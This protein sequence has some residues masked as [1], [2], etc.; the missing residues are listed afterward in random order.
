MS[1]CPVCGSESV[2]I[3]FVPAR[4]PLRRCARCG[5]RFLE[6]GGFDVSAAY[7]D[8]YEG[9]RPDA[10]FD[11]RMRAFFEQH[12]LPRAPGGS[13]LDVGCGGGALLRIATA[14]GF[15]ALGFDLSP[16]AV[17]ACE[18]KGLRAVAGDFLTHDFG[19]QRFGLIT[20]WDVLEHLPDPRPFVER[21]HALLEP[22]GWFVA[23]VPLHGEVSVRAVASIPRLAG[24]VLSVPVHVQFYTRH[25]LDGLL[26][27]RFAPKRWIEGGGMHRRATE[28]NL[29]RRLARRVVRAIHTA[30]GD[31]SLVV[32]AQRPVG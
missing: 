16:A 3:G 20:C 17:A 2:A 9:F 11:A 14:L 15:D 25:S 29:R 10:T 1:A 27:D 12:V 30:S 32:L 26:G 31:A 19:A 24:P 6:L 8:G 5:H 7:G 23:K 28:G 13:L 4:F 22:G 21:A 18:A